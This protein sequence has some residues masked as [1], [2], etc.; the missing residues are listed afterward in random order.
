VHVFC[1]YR[2]LVKEQQ[3]QKQIARKQRAAFDQA[4]DVGPKNNVYFRLIKVMLAKW[5]EA[6]PEKVQNHPQT[7]DN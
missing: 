3:L 1:H 2:L 5:T 4:A 7:L 6:N